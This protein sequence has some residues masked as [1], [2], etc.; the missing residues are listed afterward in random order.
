MSVREC[1]N[2]QHFPR[3]Q[4]S[5]ASKMLILPDVGMVKIGGQSKNRLNSEILTLKD[6]PGTWLRKGPV[7]DR[8]AWCA[9]SLSVQLLKKAIP[10][11]MSAEQKSGRRFGFGGAPPRNVEEMLMW[12]LQWPAT[13]KHVDGNFTDHRDKRPRACRH[14][15]HIC[16]R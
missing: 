8:D 13:V 7:A 1:P 10:R 4:S 2:L 14:V 15:A 9:V 3:S 16:E 5:V 12:W 11:L 6:A